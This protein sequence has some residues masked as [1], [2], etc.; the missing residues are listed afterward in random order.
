M[1]SHALKRLVLWS[2]IGLG[3]FAAALLLLRLG[4]IA[5]VV[6]TSVRAVGS[7]IGA[8]VTKDGLLAL[9]PGMTEDQVVALIG[10]PICEHTSRIGAR[11]GVPG[12]DSALWLYAR[13]SPV[14]GGGFEIYVRLKAGRLTSVGVEEFDLGIYGCDES[15]CPIWYGSR[16]GLDH[17]GRG[18]RRVRPW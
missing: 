18:S 14:F 4:L 6:N 12:Q 11:S 13:P 3:G 16:K 17:L 7:E 9:R 8:S 1:R 15:Q 5:L 2:S 10:A